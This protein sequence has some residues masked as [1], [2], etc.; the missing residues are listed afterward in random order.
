MP[1]RPEPDYPQ[2]LHLDLPV[3]DVDRAE[4]LAMRLG[5]TRLQDNGD[6]GAGRLLRRVARHAP[7]G[8]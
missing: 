6:V 3:A 2:Q 7:H 5:A 4:E 8:I 1:R